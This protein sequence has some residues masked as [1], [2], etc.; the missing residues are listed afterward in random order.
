MGLDKFYTQQ[1][2]SKRCFDFLQKELSIPLTATYLEP[3][4]G[5]GSFLDYLPNYVALDIAPDDERIIQQDYLLYNTDKTDFITIGNP[6]F[7]NRSK[8]AIDFFNKAAK[9][10][11]V[12]A[13][14]VP[15]SFMKWSVQKNLDNN[16][17]LHSY[18][19]LEPESFSSNGE[20]YSV[21][22]VFQIWVKK[23]TRYDNNI[24]LRLKK[25]PPISHPDFQIWQYN[26]T[27]EAI[28]YV[29]ED[30]KYATYRQG[31]HDYNKIFTHEDYNYIKEKM[32]AT[33]KQQFFFIKPLTEEAEKIILNMDFNALAERN[34][35]TPGF[36]KGDFVS[37]YTELKNDIDFLKKL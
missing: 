9:M 24:N 27:P 36:G 22:T 37:Y 31:F 19:Y 13:F 14:I 33:K 20:P 35:A 5:A 1:H 10:S 29:E 25:Q 23:D 16:F 18:L 21:R 12:I 6:P 8:L 11:E 3:S 34:T 30:W 15:V 28:K 4:A 26:A 32:T 7:G 17:V 2:V